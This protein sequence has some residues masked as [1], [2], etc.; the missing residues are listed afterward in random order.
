M[1]TADIYNYHDDIMNYLPG[2]R[3]RERRTPGPPLGNAL[4]ELEINEV[5]YQI[6]ATNGKERNGRRKTG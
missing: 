6:I 5:I 3:R 2:V 1:E 4:W